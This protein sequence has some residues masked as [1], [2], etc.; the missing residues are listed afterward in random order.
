[1]V[2]CISYERIKPVRRESIVCNLLEFS[3]KGES[4]FSKPEGV[5]NAYA[6]RIFE[7]EC[8]DLLGHFASSAADF[9]KKDTNYS[10]IQESVHASRQMPVVQ[11]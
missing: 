7:K 3:L 1:M 5:F 10:L 4:K 2:T 9:P 8:A 11:R 6:N